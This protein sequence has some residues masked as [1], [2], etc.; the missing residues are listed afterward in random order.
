MAKNYGVEMS[1]EDILP[2]VKAWRKANR[3]IVNFWYRLEDAIY[4]T[5]LDGQPRRYSRI[6]IGIKDG[7]LH[8]FL[9]SGRALIYREIG[10]GPDRRPVNARL[11][12]SFTASYRSKRG[13]ITFA[14]PRGP[15]RE[16][17]YGGKLV[18]NVVQAV[19][20][21]LLV[22]AMDRLSRAGFVIVGHVHD[23]V[24]AD[25]GLGNNK[26]SD[27]EYIMKHGPAW[28]DGLPLDAVG[29]TG[30]RYKKE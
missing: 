8:V 26:L 12:S 22:D 5:I 3:H 6:K 14:D 16:E 9:P 21:D 15:W 30:D 2:I 24:V 29:W 10:L 27:M 1:E 4:Q 18:E 28:A 7:H 19:A 17:T 13:K 23:E 20:R 25:G 11:V